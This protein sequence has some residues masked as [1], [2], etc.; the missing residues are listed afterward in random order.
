MKQSVLVIIKPDGV[1]KHLTGS[2]LNKFLGQDL[3]LV[4]I[5][6]VHVSDALA[7]AHYAP[8]KKQPFFSS[9]VKYLT[10]KFH[11]GAAVVAFVLEGEDAIVRCRKIAGLTNPEEADPRSVRGA[12]G[13]IT[14]YGL[15]EN[16]VHVSSDPKEARREIKLWFKKS[17]LL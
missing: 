13:R 7:K 15:W 9:I 16:A 17:E 1:Y 8:L 2:I 6:T 4:G 3:D 11:H 5:K 14:T 12:F 10:G